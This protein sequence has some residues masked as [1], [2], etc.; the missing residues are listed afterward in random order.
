MKTDSTLIICPRCQD[1]FC[2]VKLGAEKKLIQFYKVECDSCGYYHYTD[3]EPMMKT[4]STLIICPRC[5]DK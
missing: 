1:K 5:Q 2:A 3:K 4:D